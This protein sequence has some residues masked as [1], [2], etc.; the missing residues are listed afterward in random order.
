MKGSRRE[1][2]EK[3]A[4]LT[5]GSH[6]PPLR[7]FNDDTDTNRDRPPLAECWWDHYIIDVL[8]S[9]GAGLVLGMWAVRWLNLN[10]YDWTGRDKK[11]PVPMDPLKQGAMLARQFMPAEFVAYE[12]KLVE[13][14]R[15]LFAAV[16]LVVL[17]ELTELNA[18]FLKYVLYMPPETPLNAYRL[19]FWFLLSLPATREYYAYATD[20]AVNRLGP[21]AWLSIVLM[22]VETMVCVKFARSTQFPAD[23]GLELVVLQ[24]WAVAGGAFLVWCVLK[25]NPGIDRYSLLGR[26]RATVMNLLITTAI[27]ALGYLA[28]SQ[29]KGY[30]T[31]PARNAG[32]AH[33]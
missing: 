15:H 1:F 2:G 32:G 10:P 3:R 17:M 30:G 25:Y 28:Y 5:R 16:L 26:Y 9:N 27:A 6:V 20:S 12:W 24:C 33:A 7:I 21:N 29:D 19:C 14:A 23:A 8:L 22:T 4:L 13:N 18:F 31:E 11:H